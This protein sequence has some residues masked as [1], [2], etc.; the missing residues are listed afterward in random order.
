MDD[1]FTQVF[2]KHIAKV[3][4]ILDIAGSMMKG[5]QEEQLKKEIKREIWFIHDDLLDAFDINYN[6][7]KSELN[8]LIND[9]VNGFKKN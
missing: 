5:V 4:G 1:R 3:M 7:N 2:K 8:P 6:G 9:I